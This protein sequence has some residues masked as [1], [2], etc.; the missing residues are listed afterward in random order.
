MSDD[1]QS[2]A[3]METSDD[4]LVWSLAEQNNNFYVRWCVQPC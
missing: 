2:H 1:A 4:S 3:N